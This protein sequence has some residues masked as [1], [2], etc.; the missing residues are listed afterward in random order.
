MH[1]ECRNDMHCTFSS[2]MNRNYCSFSKVQILCAGPN[3]VLG[4]DREYA[5]RLGT[6]AQLRR[7]WQ[8]EKGLET[9]VCVQAG[10]LEVARIRKKLLRFSMHGN[11][12][13]HLF[14]FYNWNLDRVKP[15]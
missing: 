13:F 9:A 5:L 15:A 4:S 14:S 2:V 8:S 10:Q 1:R 7:S 3:R 6:Q 12:H 11:F